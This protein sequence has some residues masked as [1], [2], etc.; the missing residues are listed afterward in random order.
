MCKETSVIPAK[1]PMYIY[2]NILL[3]IVIRPTRIYE[4]IIGRKTDYFVILLK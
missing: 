3:D 1:Y 4:S 2:I